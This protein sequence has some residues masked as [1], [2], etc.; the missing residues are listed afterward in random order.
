MPRQMYD[1]TNPF[2]I[3]QGVPM[4]AGYVDGDYAWTVEG[5][6]R[7]LGATS[8]RISCLGSTYAA[9]VIDV[10][11]GC[12]DAE[13]A[14]AWMLVKK[15]RGELPTAYFSRSRYEEILARA[16]ADGLGDYDWNIW[17]ADWDGVNAAP[18]VGVAKQYANPAI[19]GAHY[20][21]SWV[22]D[23]WPGVDPLPAQPPTYGPA[24]GAEG[25]HGLVAVVDVDL[26]NFGHDMGV[27]ASGLQT[28]G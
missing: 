7:H 6:T 4:V 18:D 23:Y 14:I 8:V 19:T 2:D 21:L 15:S 3:P 28:L 27:L 5:W 10:E 17:V 22:S 24:A 1:S 16:R 11:A 12:V 9:E 25:W 13:T 26:P 20:D